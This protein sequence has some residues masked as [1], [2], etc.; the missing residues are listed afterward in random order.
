MNINENLICNHKRN[1]H[2]TG[3]MIPVYILHDMTNF[4]LLVDIFKCQFKKL[5]FV[6][7]RHS[8]IL[9]PVSKKI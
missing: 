8:K 1:E 7:F 9:N 6:Y 2:R 3:K 5:H 4:N